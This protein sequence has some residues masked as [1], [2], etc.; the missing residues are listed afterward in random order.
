MAS[1]A[2]LDLPGMSRRAE[3]AASEKLENYRPP[4]LA[5]V[6][7]RDQKVRAALIEEIARAR[8]KDEKEFATAVETARRHNDDI[9]RAIR[10]LEL[11]PDAM[12]EALETY[13]ALD[14]LPFSVE[15]IDTIF[16]DDRVI[17]IVDGLDL[18][19]MPEETVSL[20][21][22]GKASFKTL[23]AA[24]RMELHREAI[25]SAAVRVAIEY[26]SA[27]PI[28]EVEVLMLSDTLDRATG[29]IDPEPVLYLRTT[30][31]ALRLVNLERADPVALVERLGGHFDWNRKDGLRP[32]NAA[33][34]GI[35]LS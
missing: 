20:L 24:K 14:D 13:S 25:C 34:F 5:R 29:Y 30:L 16:L 4:W 27:L 18:E 3:A 28:E 19:D 7:K 32:I 33:A 1:A 6:M 9:S 15:G 26:F 17:A 35:D 2:P 8:V 10:V 12:I 23:T 31:Q 22:S 21:K 11:D